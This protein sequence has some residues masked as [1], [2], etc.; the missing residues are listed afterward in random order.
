MEPTPVDLVVH[1]KSTVV[2]ANQQWFG[3]ARTTLL[4]CCV[5]CGW[6]RTSS[7]T[8]CKLIS[9]MSDIGRVNQCQLTS[10]PMGEAVIL[11][12]LTKS[13]HFGFTL[14]SCSTSATI[15]PSTAKPAAACLTHGDRNQFIMAAH[16]RLVSSHTCG[17]AFVSGTFLVA[18]IIRTRHSPSVWT[19][20]QD[21]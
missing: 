5:M 18:P 1:G 11:L 8:L 3:L 19:I 17:N 6:H 10:S 16:S 7:G 21:A 20:S 12:P 14:V 2:S 9:S 4:T 13:V 15:F